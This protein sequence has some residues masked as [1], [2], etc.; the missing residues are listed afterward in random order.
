MCQCGGPDSR[1]RRHLDQSWPDWLDGFEMTYLGADT[2]L[3]GPVADQAALYGVTS[4]IR[5]SG[6]PIQLAEK[7]AHEDK[8]ESKA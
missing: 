4:I 1:S 6:L 8:D 5:D 3:T 2:T 7:F